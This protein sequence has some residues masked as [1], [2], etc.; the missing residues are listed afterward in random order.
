MRFSG[1]RR[2]QEGSSPQPWGRS[3]IVIHA[4]SPRNSRS[5]KIESHEI[6]RKKETTGRVPRLNLRNRGTPV[7]YKSREL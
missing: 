6:F 5:L 4:V 2:L 3:G 7:P 1:R